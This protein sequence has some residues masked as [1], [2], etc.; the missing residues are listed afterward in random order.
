M[1][2]CC[3]EEGWFLVLLRWVKAETSDA[4][5]RACSCECCLTAFQV[6]LRHSATPPNF[7]ESFQGISGFMPQ[8]AS[9][10]EPAGAGVVLAESS[11][12]NGL[13]LSASGEYGEEDVRRSRFWHV[14]LKIVILLEWMNLFSNIFARNV[15]TAENKRYYI[16]PAF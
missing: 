4:L 6:Y 2:F 13:S 15:L 5:Q 12:L 7:F 16:R 8:L 9:F 11:V 3:P 10:T 1:Y 14:F